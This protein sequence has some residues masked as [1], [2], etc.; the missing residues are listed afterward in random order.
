MNRD[1]F[2]GKWK[3]MR[4]QV[5]IWWGKLTDDDLEKA[6]GKV[7]KLIGLLQQKY[8]YTREQAEKEFN[9]RLEA[10]K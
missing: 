10:L 3:E 9:K 7:D 2:E 8:G 6:G 5:K 4:G 1:I